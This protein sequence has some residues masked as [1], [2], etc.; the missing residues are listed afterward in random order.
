MKPLFHSNTTEALL[1]YLN[2]DGHARTL[3]SNSVLGIEEMIEGLV[4]RIAGKPII[5][6]VKPTG[7]TITIDQIRDLKQNLSL[8]QI[9]NQTR[10][11]IVFNAELMS[12][13]AQNSF[14]K[15]LE[16]PPAGIK[17]LLVTQ[18]YG[19]LLTTI[20]SRAARL[21][22]SPITLEEAEDH[23]KT[24]GVAT[25]NIRRSHAI[26]DGQPGIMF[27][28]LS[29]PESAYA[30]VLS[31]AKKIISMDPYQ[32][33]LLVDQVVKDKDNQLQLLLALHDILRAV[34]RAAGLKGS[35]QTAQLAVK[36]KALLDAAVSLQQHA[37]AKL[38][39]TDVFLTI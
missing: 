3:A 30:D 21:H 8:K 39:F 32:R 1:R 4:Q 36:R 25:D 37:N 23:Y 29:Q 15:L 38:L 28:L 2:G 31:Q 24:E 33:L 20:T 26:S 22:I 12:H 14:L 10:I 19:A 5:V 18:Q 13:E 9:G 35:G 17:I 7:S 11:I 6:P 16:E 27:T 34:T